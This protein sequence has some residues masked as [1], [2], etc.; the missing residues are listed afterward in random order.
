MRTRQ[1]CQTI[2]Q[3]VLGG[4]T[5]V[6]DKVES[7]KTS[8]VV[9]CSDGWDRT[10]QVINIHSFLFIYYIFYY[11]YNSLDML[12]ISVTSYSVL[13]HKRYHFD[14]LSNLWEYVN[15]IVCILEQGCLYIYYVKRLMCIVWNTF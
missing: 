14:S 15:T 13:H 7:N 9:H 8:V 10:A 5:R 1:I 3:Q 11:L 2:L 6:A 4:A 12:A